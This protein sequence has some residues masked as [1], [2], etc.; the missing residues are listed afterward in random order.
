MNLDERMKRFRI[1]SRELF[2]AYFRMPKGTTSEEAFLEEE[3]FNAVQELLFIK[4]VTE[5][6]GIPQ[7]QHFYQNAQPNI[8]VAIET[9][10][11]IPA[12]INREIKSG[13]W[14]YPIGRVTNET[15][16]LFKTFF[17]FDSL[18]YRDNQ[19]VRAKI[20]RWPSQPDVVGKDVLLESQYVCFSMADSSTLAES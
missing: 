14:D 19:Y 17:D 8:R 16:M 20:I 1:A 5:P 15:I 9:V 3:R 6:L 11:S 13:Y 7:Q 4:L 2:N 12:L 10:D 18:G